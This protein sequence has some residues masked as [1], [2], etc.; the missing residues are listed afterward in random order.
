MAHIQASGFVTVGA[1]RES[2][3]R[4]G[5]LPPEEQDTYKALSR[6][7]SVLKEF[8]RS[9]ELKTRLIG[10][11]LRAAEQAL[12][13]LEEPLMLSI[14]TLESDY[15][16]VSREINLLI[17]SIQEEEEEAPPLPPPVAPPL[18]R[19]QAPSPP[20]QEPSPVQP[21]T[22]HSSLSRRSSRMTL[23]KAKD[24]KIRPP[25]ALLGDSHK[26]GRK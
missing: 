12:R 19:P 15:E 21:T 11:Q 4:F 18:H 20:Q 6:T 14:D 17:S 22:S 16:K 25:P 10:G 2:V 7:L 3:Y 5:V 9:L 13:E 23:Q 1:T 8:E 24:D 26:R